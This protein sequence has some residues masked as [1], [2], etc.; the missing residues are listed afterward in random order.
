MDNLIQVRSR[1]I[2]LI[3]VKSE[4]AVSAD[5]LGISQYLCIP[6]PEFRILVCV[7]TTAAVARP[8]YMPETSVLRDYRR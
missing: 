3:I 2:P 5:V 8:P 1:V 7:G 4:E 6:V